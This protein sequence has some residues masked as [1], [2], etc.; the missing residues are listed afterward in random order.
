MELAILGRNPGEFRLQGVPGCTIGI[1]DKRTCLLALLDVR[2]T[3]LLYL[4][5]AVCK[6]VMCMNKFEYDLVGNWAK[7]NHLSL[8][9]TKSK[10]MFVTRSHS[11][12]CPLI[13][14]HGARLELASYPGRS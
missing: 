11:R 14:L 3:I 8:N 5:F 6:I 7:S 12:Q 10:L 4:H 13:F 2:N 1:K 9:V